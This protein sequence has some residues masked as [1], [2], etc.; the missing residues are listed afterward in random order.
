MNPLATQ[1][2]ARALT[3][4]GYRTAEVHNAR[5]ALELLANGELRFDLVITD[6]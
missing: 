5:Q 4:A 6:V 3:A 2:A 1:V